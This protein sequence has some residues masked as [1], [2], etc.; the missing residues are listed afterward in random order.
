MLVPSGCAGPSD[1]EE[2][3]PEASATATAGLPDAS[4]SSETAGSESTPSTAAVATSVTPAAVPAPSERSTADRSVAPPAVVV[5]LTAVEVRAEAGG[6]QVV[7]QTSGGVPGWSLRY[8]DAVRVDGEPVLVEGEAAL[9]LVLEAAN[10]DGEQ[11]LADDVAVDLTPDQPLVR[12]VRFA[13]YLGNQVVFAVGLSQ[14]VAFS[15][16]TTATALV[17]TFHG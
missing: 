12:E 11:G 6:E 7:I 2:T 15:V 5:T 3:P 4:P 17:I 8:V 13:Q 10:P 16:S 1:P 14:Q 9:E